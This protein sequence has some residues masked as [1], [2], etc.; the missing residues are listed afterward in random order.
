[1]TLKTIWLVLTRLNRVLVTINSFRS[2]LKVAN[3]LKNQR[4]QHAATLLT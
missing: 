1:M 3:V 2:Q 4:G